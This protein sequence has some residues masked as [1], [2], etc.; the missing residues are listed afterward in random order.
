MLS[1]GRDEFFGRERKKLRED[2][3]EQIIDQGKICIWFSLIVF[4]TIVLGEGGWIELNQQE[5]SL[6]AFGETNLPLSAVLN[7]AYSA[8]TQ[9]VPIS[10]PPSGFAAASKRCTTAQDSAGAC[11]YAALAATPTTRTAVAGPSDEFVS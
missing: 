3:H 2:G 8:K 1:D 7:Q 11:V 5:G 4:L 6:N 9:F 10:E